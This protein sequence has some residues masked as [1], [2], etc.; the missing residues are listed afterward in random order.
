MRWQYSSHG[1]EIPDLIPAAGSP[2]PN[3]PFEQGGKWWVYN[4][5]RQLMG[6]DAEKNEWVLVEAPAP[7]EEP[8]P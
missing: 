8:P 4:L 7:K 1:D 2:P 5:S 3:Q 6:W